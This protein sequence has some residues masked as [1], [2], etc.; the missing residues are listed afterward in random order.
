MKVTQESVVM[1]VTNVIGLCVM[2]FGMSQDVADAIRGAVPT[3]VGGVMSLVSAIAYIVNRR[4]AKESVLNAV[5]AAN[6]TSA[7]GEGRDIL[8]T[9]HEIGLI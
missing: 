7:R 1:L 5:A 6:A 2:F 8:L 3:V 9:A 4:K